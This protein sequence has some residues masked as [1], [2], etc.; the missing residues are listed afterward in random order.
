M[1][2]RKTPPKELS[3]SI[4]QLVQRKY[5]SEP[6]EFRRL[7]PEVAQLLDAAGTSPRRIRGSAFVLT[8]R[9][10]ARRLQSLQSALNSVKSK[11][12]GRADAAG[13]LGDYAALL[14]DDSLP[15]AM[16][17]DARTALFKAVAGKAPGS[18]GANEIVPVADREAVRSVALMRGVRLNLTWDLQLVSLSVSPEQLRERK[19]L[20]AFVGSGRDAASDVAARHDDYL[21]A[22]SPH[23]AS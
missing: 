10:R 15:D 8:E 12:L 7:L 5:A 2:A 13:A 18:F 6:D 4:V 23:G 17:Y 3:A 14:D 21:A 19:R 22:T 1:S 20:L 11:S 9:E 16:D